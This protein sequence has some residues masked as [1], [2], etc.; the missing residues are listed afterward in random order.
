MKPNTKA[1]NKP[2]AKILQYALNTETGWFEQTDCPLGFTKCPVELK[3]ERTQRPEKIN[4]THVIRSRQ[5]GGRYEFFT[6][7][8]SAGVPYLFFGDVYE[9]RNGKKVNSFCLFNFT[10]TYQHLT[11]HIFPGYKVFPNR[12]RA[13]IAS[14]WR[15]VGQ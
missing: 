1:A 11:V 8:I 3:V 13:F 2:E 7:L 10:E 6:G 9:F 15:E 14:Y 5:K 4:S 12:R